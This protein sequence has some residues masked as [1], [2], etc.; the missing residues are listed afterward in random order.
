MVSF[1]HALIFG[2]IYLVALGAAT[3]VVFARKDVTA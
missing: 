2:P 3:T 1:T